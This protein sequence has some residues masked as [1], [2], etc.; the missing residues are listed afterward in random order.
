LCCLGGAHDATTAAAWALHKA[1]L[2]A[3]SQ[4]IAQFG[5][6]SNAVAALGLKK[7]SEYRRPPR[8]SG[9]TTIQP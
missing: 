3:K 5:P 4:V 1:V 9:K 2:G 8:R 6:D 7:K